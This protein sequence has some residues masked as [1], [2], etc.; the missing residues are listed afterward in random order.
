MASTVNTALTMLYWPIGGRI[1]EDILKGERTE[2]GAEILATV[3]QESV[4]DRVD[5]VDQMDEGCNERFSERTLSKDKRLLPSTLSTL[6]K[7]S[8]IV[9]FTD[10]KPTGGN[11]QFASRIKHFKYFVSGIA[12]SAGWSRDWERV[13][14]SRSLRPLDCAADRSV[15]RK[16]SSLMW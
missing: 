1:N 16:R 8:T 2:Y 10:R 14:R 5:L 15:S 13:W 6:S 9:L 11:H 7:Q 3:S 4:V 12:R